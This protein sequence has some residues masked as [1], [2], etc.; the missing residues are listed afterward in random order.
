M[1]KDTTTPEELENEAPESAEEI[2]KALQSVEDVAPSHLDILPLTNRP[3][4]P[5]FTLP[6]NFT[7]ADNLKVIKHAIDHNDGYLGLVLKK[8]AEDNEEDVQPD[9]Y[10]V[11][12]AFK[13]LRVQPFAPNAL[14]VLGQGVKRFVRHKVIANQPTIKWEVRYQQAPKEKVGQALKAYMMA[15]SSEI[16]NLLKLN[17]L[18][19]EQLNLV[20]SQ[21]NYDEP[22]LTMDLISNLLSVEGTTLQGLLE[23]FDLEERAKMLLQLVKE[24]LEVAKIQKRINEEI[25]EKVNEQ[26]KEFFLRRQLDAIKKELGIEKDEKETELEKLEKKL[27]ERNLPDEALKV[28]KEELDKLKTLNPQS[29]EFNVTRSYLELISDLP[30]GEYSEDNVDIRHARAVL[31]REHYGLDDVKELILEFLASV[32]RRG[33]IA[34]SIICLVGPPGVG[35]TSIGKSVAEA[36][37]RKFFRFSVGGMRDEAEIKG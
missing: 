25:N 35:K 1:D 15:I 37:D 10:E 5:G 32:I 28:V 31:D 3:I 19:K 22:G 17:P 34:G 21:L 2:S 18:F 29:P 4:F 9:L 24:E 36:L 8:N 27:A 6:L 12:T 30:W 13:I 14:Q 7:G 20:V 23:T 26:Q 11:G 33:K 16:Q